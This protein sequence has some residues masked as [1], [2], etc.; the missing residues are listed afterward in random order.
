MIKYI[1]D[2]KEAYIGGN[3]LDDF[4]NLH[5]GVSESLLLNLGYQKVI[6]DDS[7]APEVPDT[8]TYNNL[9]VSK[10]R[11][12][13]SIDDELAIIRQKEDKP[14]EFKAYDEYCEQCKSEVKSLLHI[15]E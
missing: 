3:I 13:Y 4:Q 15:T 5:I 9:V 6:I 10:I 1:K 2:G 7:T 8:I 11:N 14:D 12:K